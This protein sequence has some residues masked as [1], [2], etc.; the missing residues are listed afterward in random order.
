MIIYFIIFVH[1]NSFFR[2]MCNQF[3]LS[4]A[5]ML[6]IF[7]YLIGLLQLFKY[8]QLWKFHMI[9][10][11]V[12]N[13]RLKQFRILNSKIKS[14]IKVRVL[15]SHKS[16]LF[17]FLENRLWNQTIIDNLLKTVFSFVEV[18]LQFMNLEIQLFETGGVGCIH[19]SL[20]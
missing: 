6:H 8:F 11:W 13:L 9:L 16:C 20:W 15:I 17:S 12:S 7:T 3:G 1:I 19:L 14:L 2:H 5:Y 10:S 4:R 18:Q